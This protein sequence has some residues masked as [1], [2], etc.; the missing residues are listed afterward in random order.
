MVGLG[1]FPCGITA[2]ATAQPVAS[3]RAVPALAL[4]LVM[5]LLAGVIR[6]ATDNHARLNREAALLSDQMMAELAARY[7]SADNHEV[8]RLLSQWQTLPQIRGA[9]LRTGDGRVLAVAGR[10]SPPSAMSEALFG[11]AVLTRK[12]TQGDE[13]VGELNLFVDH[14]FLMRLLLRDVLYSLLALVLSITIA[15]V[16]FHRAMR[17]MSQHLADMNAAMTEMAV[18]GDFSVRLTEPA[19]GNVREIAVLSRSLNALMDE[20]E[21][22]NF[23]MECELESSRRTDVHLG[24]LSLAVENSAAGIF[25]ADQD[26]WIEYANPFYLQ[27]CGYEGSECFGMPS[28]LIRNNLIAEDRFNAMWEAL[29]KGVHWQGE[30]KIQRQG[31]EGFWAVLALSSVRNDDGSLAH[32]IGNLEDISE[33]KRAEETINRLAFYDAL[34]QLPNRYSFNEQLPRLLA[35]ASRKDEMVAV[36]YLDL[37]RFKEVNDT[38]GHSM[39]DHLLQTAAKRLQSVLREHDVVARLGGDEFALLIPGLHDRSGAEVVAR[40]IIDHMTTPFRLDG[41]ELS[42]TASMGMVFYPESGSDA[43]DLLK[44]ADIALYR[45]KAMGRNN[46]QIFSTGMEEVGLAH[47]EMEAQIR[48]SLV[49]EDFCIE[50]Q[51]KLDLNTGMMCWAEALVRWDHPQLGRLSPDKFIPLAEESSLIIPLSNWIINEVMRQQSAWRHAGLT[52]VPVAINLSTRQFNND[53]LPLRVSEALLKHDVAAALIDFEITESLMMENPE[54]VRRQLVE[55]DVMGI[56]IAIDDFGTGYSSLSYLQRLP[57][58][59]LKIDRSFVH[60]VENA[61]NRVIQAIIAMAKSLELQ[62]VAEGA[63][64][65]SQVAYLRGLGCDVI[66][67]YVYS[68]PLPP[69]EFSR[70]LAEPA[71]DEALLEA[72]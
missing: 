53:D 35:L 45:A 1:H 61:D 60:D 59:V 6:D 13:V 67:G 27:A 24:Q 46:F 3:C 51:P 9:S 34:T 63:E 36:C 2:H 4:A 42:V 19:D 71:R 16:L 48:Q 11:R 49:A 56:G 38:L 21:G 50:Y 58:D 68:R 18:S 43:D 54:R 7:L 30:V 26:G 8:Q 65:A 70:L 22:R 32:I 17:R 40:K 20:V 31:G 23:N 62:V 29:R 47:R 72:R 28:P 37:D 14:T 57:V 52:P 5:L 66:Q 12:V 15:A 25:I 44:K 33:Y 10:V 41:R 64:T 39:G 69:A 55:L